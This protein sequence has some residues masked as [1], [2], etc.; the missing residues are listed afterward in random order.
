MNKFMHFHKITASLI[1]ASFTSANVLAVSPAEVI[2]GNEATDTITITK[3]LVDRFSI[4]P[5]TP[6]ELMTDI[7]T[8]FIDTPYTNF[9]LEGDTEQLTVNLDGFDC[10]TFVETVTALTN[11]LQERRS[12]WIDFIYNLER[13]RYRSGQLTDYSSRLHYFSDWVLDNSHR[14][15]IKE[16]TDR[17]ANTSHQVKTLDF[18]TTHRNK[19][20][21]LADSATFARIKNVEVGYRNHKYPYIKP[22]NIAGAN[23]KPGDIIA[24]TT[25][26]RGLDV[27]HVG[28]AVK[29]NGKIHLLHASSNEGKVCITKKPLAEYVRQNHAA[30]GIRVVRLNE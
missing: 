21:A 27:S 15:I 14:G 7:G 8:L 25:K 9:P 13:I 17:I 19:Y 30:S 29:I 16:V 6:A 18:M 5:R 11:T 12:S 10:T 26:T 20:P 3:I 22:Q 2:F 23:I 24:I 28:I 4:T 1:I